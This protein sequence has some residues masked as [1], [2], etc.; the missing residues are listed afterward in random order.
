M[1]NMGICKKM[2]I[3]ADTCGVALRGAPINGYEFTK[4]IP[5]AN[6]QIGWLSRV[7][8]VLAA[9]PHSAV[10][11]K[12]IF[13][14]N[15]RRSPKGNL[16]VQHTAVAKLDTSADNTIRANGNI[17]TQTQPLVLPPQAND[18]HRPKNKDSI[19]FR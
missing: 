11:I 12:F 14:P 17:V 10:W 8:K 2:T 1:G 15:E 16:A 3:V 18:K 19:S 9:S 6:C 4:G 5:G 13:S 7:F